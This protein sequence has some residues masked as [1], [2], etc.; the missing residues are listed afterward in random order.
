M[1]S[2][3]YVSFSSAGTRGLMYMGVLDAMEDC[4]NQRHGPGGF[5]AWRQGLE[6]V[7]GTSAGSLPALLL[8]LGL[9]RDQRH[10]IMHHCSDMRAV[11]PCPDVTLLFRNYGVEE[12]YA[13]RDIIRE[14]LME[15]GLS[16]DSTLGDVQRLLRKEFVCM[17]SDLQTGTPV[18]LS[19]RTHPHVRVCDAVYATCCVPFLFTPIHIDG[20]L[21]V[22]GCF[23]CNT[24]KPFP[25]AETLFVNS[26]D[27]EAP[28]DTPVATWSDFLH[29]MVGCAMYA[30]REEE[31]A[32]LHT[33]PAQCLVLRDWN[34]DVKKMPAFDV[35]LNQGASDA[36]YRTGY[37]C[38][39]GFLTHGR[40]LT[41]VSALV[42]FCVE[43]L[44]QVAAARFTPALSE[45]APGDDQCSAEE[46]RTGDT[47]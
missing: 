19:T 8:L 9:S 40:V 26:R 46:I 4:M 27:P 38:A 24:P 32:L 39:L 42:Y 22:D 23:V 6:G 29:G 33:Y 36:L 14:V 17:C 31:R 3:K 37:A 13:F 44:R 25:L 10:R 20:H 12:G 35:A 11:L 18:T 28:Q 30:Q 41:A 1:E 16:A 21:V 45:S 2:C 34:D 47:R 43:S 15:G 7:A 5:E